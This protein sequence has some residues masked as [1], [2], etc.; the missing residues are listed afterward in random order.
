MSNHT[1]ALLT[2]LKAYFGAFFGFAEGAESSEMLAEDDEISADEASINAE[3]L[4]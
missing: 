3:M 2:L 1:F 4:G